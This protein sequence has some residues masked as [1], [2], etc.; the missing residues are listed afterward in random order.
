MDEQGAGLGTPQL[1]KN[2]YDLLWNGAW[3]HIQA[4]V[5]LPSIFSFFI[6]CY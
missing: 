1:E 3:Y 2:Q 5:E 4:W 6:V